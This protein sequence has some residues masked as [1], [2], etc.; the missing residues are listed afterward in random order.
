M[1][2]QCTPLEIGI[3]GLYQLHLH[4][5]QYTVFLVF[6]EVP[7]KNLKKYFWD[8]VFLV[9]FSCTVGVQSWDPSMEEQ[10]Y[11]GGWNISK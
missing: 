5:V 1:F 8:I 10:L 2:F 3:F 4:S 6:N 9:L 11:A 7:F